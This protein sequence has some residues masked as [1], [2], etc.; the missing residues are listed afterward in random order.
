[1][2]N[3]DELF[4]ETIIEKV[5]VVKFNTDRTVS[6]ANDLF[7]KTLKYEPEELIGR[8]HRD[9]CFPDFHRSPTYEAFWKDLLAGKN[10]SNNFKRKDKLGNEVW[11]QATYLPI[12]EN[13]EVVSIGKIAFD[14]SPRIQTIQNF[15]DDFASVA[16]ALMEQANSG[17]RIGH[18]LE[19]TFAAIEA[20]YQSSQEKLLHLSTESRQIHDVVRIINGIATQTNLLALNAAIEAAR[21]GEAGRGFA[22]VADEVRKLSGQVEEAIKKVEDSIKGITRYTGEVEKGFE[23]VKE[24]ILTSQ[25]EVQI[26]LTN[27]Q[28]LE[29]SS[30]EL[31]RKVLQ[32]VEKVM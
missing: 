14:I 5:P 2:K 20:S 28:Q 15:S 17:Q 9:F 22:V 30:N 19:T 21:A 13:G 27:S 24:S 4:L 12:L 6:F 32:F 16:P 26:S 23:S 31:T 18:E 7:A 1:M 25:Q 10:F 8:E 3:R 29:A 11:L